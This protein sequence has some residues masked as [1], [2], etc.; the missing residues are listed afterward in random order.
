MK[1]YILLSVMMTLAGHGFSQ[2]DMMKKHYLKI[3]NQALMYND[4][5]AAINALHGYIAEDNSLAY[6]DTLSMLYFNTK[7]YYSALLLAEEVSKASPANTDA[8]ARAAECYDL[9]GD[10]KTSVG[11]YEQVVPKTKNPYHI[12]KMAVGQYQLKRI[13]E[14]ET[15]AKAVMADTNSKKIGVAFTMADG[16]QQ[17]VPVYAA[18]A[19]LLGVL[20]M[21]TKN[22]PVAINYFKQAT[23]AFPEF[24][25]AKEN[26]KI[27]EEKTL[28]NKP[29][30]KGLSTKPPAGKPKG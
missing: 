15:S 30:L 20:Q 28:K 5:V 3:Y 22:Y 16:S 2:N 23:A 7:S 6:K 10:P 11:L 14:C 13:A 1:K 26:L 18:A 27:C 24:A 8:M 25:G 9:L 4:A 21:E 12:Y 19:N 17:A 29:V